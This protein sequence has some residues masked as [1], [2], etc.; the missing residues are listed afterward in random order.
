MLQPLFSKF[1][2]ECIV[3][4]IIFLWMNLFL[5]NWILIVYLCNEIERVMKNWSK[6]WIK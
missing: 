4:N 1:T 2:L 3:I 5:K 6:A